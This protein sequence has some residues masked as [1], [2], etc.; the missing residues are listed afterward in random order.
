MTIELPSAAAAVAAA[1][2][3]MSTPVTAPRDPDFDVDAM[4]TKILSIRNEPFGTSANLQIGEIRKLLARVKALFMKEPT[5][6]D[7]QPPITVCGDIHGQF[8]DLLRIFDN[9]HYPGETRFLFLGDYVDRGNLSTETVCLLFCYKLK[10]PNDFFMLRGNHECAYINRIYGFLDELVKQFGQEAA[11]ALH[12]E[13]NSVFQWLPFAA[14]IGEKIFC[15]H[16]GISPQL[17]SL[18]DIRN[19]QRPIEIPD[20][21]LVCDLVW[22]DPEPDCEDWDENER[23]VGKSFGPEPVDNFL[24]KF[25]LDLI[26]RGH[27][28]VVNGYEFPFTPEQT[29]ITLFSAPNYCYE[30][31][32]YGAVLHV[33]ENLYCSFSILEPRQYTS[34]DGEFCAP[35]ERPG[36]PPRQGSQNQELVEDFVIPSL[37]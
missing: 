19:I 31:D 12:L 10:Y 3:A 25:D 28:A 2:A 16:G 21:G 13:F 6:L 24:R 30:Y 5:L 29:L 26:C 11:G 27:Q 35:N 20:E 22:S 7:I 17:Q 36:T 33:Q 14:I 23:G 15:L 9:S 1:A 32:N 8:A 34:N 37:E 4:I 18:D